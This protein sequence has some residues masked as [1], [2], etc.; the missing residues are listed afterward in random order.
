MNH[1]H[2]ILSVCALF[3][4]IIMH[5]L[6]SFLSHPSTVW[7]AHFYAI[8]TLLAMINI[9]DLRV[10]RWLAHNDTPIALNDEGIQII[11][12]Q[13]NLGIKLVHQTSF[14]PKI[15]ELGEC[16]ETEVN[17]IKRVLRT[18]DQFQEYLSS[19]LQKIDHSQIGRLEDY[20]EMR[21]LPH[22]P[23]ISDR[24][25]VGLFAIKPLPRGLV[26]LWQSDLM[27][28]RLDECEHIP[29]HE[30]INKRPLGSID[31]VQVSQSGGGMLRSN[32]ITLINFSWCHTESVDASQSPYRLLPPNDL[33]PSNCHFISVQKTLNDELG[34]SSAVM[35]HRDLQVGEQLLAYSG[36]GRNAWA[37]ACRR[38]ISNTMTLLTPALI[39][40]PLIRLFVVLFS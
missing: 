3:V 19:T 30:Q 37:V 24:P 26:F 4:A 29:V 34:L 12:E 16:S 9:L 18:P 21:V 2:G 5:Y 33:G 20:L 36:R 39:I 10:R 14:I 25:Q 23:Y 38:L 31:G 40:A 7:L 11:N 8:L 6:M 17:A 22:L 28:Y 13:A 35:T 15:Y 32:P 27:I 1:Q